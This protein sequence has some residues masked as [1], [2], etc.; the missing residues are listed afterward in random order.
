[1]GR[2]CTERSFA[3]GGSDMQI[4][5]QNLAVGY[6]PQQTAIQKDFPNRKEIV[7]MNIPK[8]ETEIEVTGTFETYKE[9]EDD[10]LYGHL[11]NSK[12]QIK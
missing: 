11:V 10:M 9:S 6:L 7:R 5:C 8:D 1:M 4:S 3:V 2:R 12:L